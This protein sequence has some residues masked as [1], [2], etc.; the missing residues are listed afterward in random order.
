M[1][2]SK[3]QH[4]I[5]RIV[6]LSLLGLLFIG[7][8]V[9]FSKREALLNTAIKKAINKADKEYDLILKIESVGFAGLSTVSFKNITVA[10]LIVV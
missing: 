2:I 1:Q 3:K 5:I 10:N 9:A 8:V 4:K 7:S 6:S